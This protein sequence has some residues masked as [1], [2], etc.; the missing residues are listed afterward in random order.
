MPDEPQGA[1][2]TPA[3]TP[4]NE[5][6]TP[7]TATPDAAADQRDADNGDVN[8]GQ[9]RRDA[10]LAGEELQRALA[11]ERRTR[12][13][14]EKELKALRDEKQARA[15]AEKSDLD[16]AN[17]RAERA[18][19][20]VAEIEREMLARQVANE[21][22]IPL[23]WERLRGDDLR[24]LRADASK[25]REELGLGEGALDGGVRGLGASAQPQSMDDLIRRGAR[26]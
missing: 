2:A 16:R 5:G 17:E 4:Q 11:R 1:G 18:E 25:L 7:T 15:D 21:A 13:E 9:D 10:G 19:A 24:A 14:M 20:R 26:R 22:G 12:R 8:D 6:A 23:M 3:A